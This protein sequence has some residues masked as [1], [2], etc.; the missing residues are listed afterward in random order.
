[1]KKV[2]K[3]CTI[4][5]IVTLLLA[6]IPILPKVNAEEPINDSFGLHGKKL[7][8]VTKNSF[9]ATSNSTGAVEVSYLSLTNSYNDSYHAD[10]NI[11]YNKNRIGGRKILPKDIKNS[12]IYDEAATFWTFE[13]AEDMPVDDETTG[14]GS[15]SLGGWFKWYYI[16]TLDENG[17]KQ[18]LNL[19]PTNGVNNVEISST[20]TPVAVTKIVNDAGAI[21]EYNPFYND[22]DPSTIEYQLWSHDMEKAEAAGEKTYFHKDNTNLLKPLISIDY[23]DFGYNSGLFTTTNEIITSGNNPTKLDSTL[24]FN[25]Y[26]PGFTETTLSTSPKN[27]TS[28]Y[29][30]SSKIKL[31]NYSSEINRYNTSDKSLKFYNGNNIDTPLQ[32]A[33]DGYGN[34]YSTQYTD[35]IKSKE[36]KVEATLDENG[37]PVTNVGS[38]DYLFNDEEVA[39]KTIAGTANKSGGLF[40]YNNGYYSYDSK[41]NAAYFNGTKFELY[42]SI[43]RPEYALINGVS[44]SGKV[45]YEADERKGNFLPFNKIDSSTLSANNVVMTKDGIKSYKLSGKNEG[46]ADVWFG[47][48]LETDFEVP[49]DGLVEGEDMIFSFNADDIVLVYIDDVLVLSSIEIT[50]E[51]D[52]YINFKTGEVVNGSNT[53]SPTT[54]AQLLIDAGK[55]KDEAGNSYTYGDSLNSDIQHNM[56]MFYIERGGNLSYVKFNTNLKTIPASG[57]ENAIK[58]PENPETSALIITGVITLLTIS[59][60]ALLVLKKQKP[61]K[62]I[63]NN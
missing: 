58:T 61:N 56:K 4:I 36:I 18:Y 52:S 1:M 20:P 43:I 17:N 51:N 11:S 19:I 48:T 15:S 53:T 13:L 23:T 49:K 57:V 3:I 14:N 31:F 38:L 46:I 21:K 30:F 60:G 50:Y 39:G 42:D 41:K 32:I 47:M 45:N 44:S 35:A 54:L 29:Y 55:D 63:K 6:F 2:N 40:Q 8:I 62:F 24:L 33:K 9:T 7:A 25:F 10:T 59:C 12:K 22:E 26:E 34:T 5:M 27:I 16:Y 37:F 28:D